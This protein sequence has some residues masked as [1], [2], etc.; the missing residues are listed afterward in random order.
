M[1]AKTHM[2]LFPKEAAKERDFLNFWAPVN[3][4]VSDQAF[5]YLMVTE[6]ENFSRFHTDFEETLDSLITLYGCGEKVWFFIRPGKFCR[7]LEAH[8]AT[9][10]FSLSVY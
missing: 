9:P 6:G 1:G 7:Q 3:A 2:G 4:Q 8:Y 10:A 5:G